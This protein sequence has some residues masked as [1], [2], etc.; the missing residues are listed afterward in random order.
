MTKIIALPARPSPVPAQPEGT[1]LIREQKRFLD[2]LPEK[3]NALGMAWKKLKYINWDVQILASLGK[4]VSALHDTSQSLLLTRITDRA[5]E[6]MQVLKLAI[7][8]GYATAHQ[9]QDI[10]NALTQLGEAI[11]MARRYLRGTQRN[12]EPDA[13]PNPVLCVHVALVEEDPHQSALTRHLLE[14]TGYQVSVF[15]H[16]R[17]LN[18]AI[19]DTFFNIILLDTTFHDGALAGVVWLEAMRH[20]L[21][22]TS[23]I[24]LSARTDIVARLRA[25]RAGAHAYVTKGNDIEPLHHKI[26]QALRYLHHPKD[27]V[28]IV[29]NDN[30][31]LTLMA[32]RL[33]SEGFA[34]DTLNM[35]LLLLERLVRLRPD[36]V[37]LNYDLPG[38]NGLELGN[39]LRQ[40]PT[41]M[42][43]PIV[44]MADL[45]Q[46][47]A[48]R[49]ALSLLGNACL[50]LPLQLNALSDTLRHEIQRARMVAGPM[51]SSTETTKEQGLQH[52][53]AFYAELETLLTDA[54]RPENRSSAWYL[55]YVAVDAYSQLK[56]SLRLRTLIEQEETIE[57]YF[58][59]RPEID[60]MGC[61][62]GEMRYVLV[63]HDIEGVGG[64]TLIQRLHTT[65]TRHS[66]GNLA[67]AGG[68]TLSIGISVLHTLQSV[69]DAIEQT[70][71]ACLR[72]QR[73]GGDQVAWTTVV[74][75]RKT[76]LTTPMRQA[77]RNRSFK[78]VY[79]PIVNLDR[80]DVWFEALVRLVDAQGQ[81]YL[82]HQFLDWVETDMEGGSFSLDRMI[83][84]QGLEALTHLGGKSGAGYSLVVKL[85]PDLLQCERL[86]PY[87]SNVVNGARLRGVRRTT[88]SLP[89]SC[90]MSDIPRA[91]RLIRH[92]H[93]LN[94]GVMLEQVSLTPQSL[95]QLRELG[96]IDFIKL[97]ASWRQQIEKDKHFRTLIRNVIEMMPDVR[98]VASHVEDAKSFATLW[99]A[100]VRYFQGY[101]IQEP[102]EQ[103]TAAPFEAAV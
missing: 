81:V 15:H 27:H 85:T 94:C 35:P 49:E 89:E 99:E 82:P 44:Y 66:Q 2:Y 23:V 78:L 79:Q 53:A 5:S 32:E 13:V 22:E 76:Q 37:V 6:L 60:G 74:P 64:E 16:P 100:G 25:V 30:G 92:I 42:S 20:Q 80:E 95:Q 24:M 47:A 63:V 10:D 21:Q 43:I 91:R 12:V 84:E 17:Q 55:A 70:E 69:D 87:I 9:R 39:L 7:E 52:R 51:T 46:S 8:Q 3:I 41:L 4:G 58:S 88:L 19:S 77:L 86:L 29:D 83:I 67:N 48:T 96:A 101:F 18:D 34:V 36:V 72:A 103:L 90:V 31:Q 75:L 62:L 98:L 68:L 33:L 26:Q 45:S 1:L 11:D 56:K 61:C 97:N 14:Q 50:P 57:R 65:A 28:L 54:S 59:V 40:D 102:G 38:C 73:D 93:G 71:T